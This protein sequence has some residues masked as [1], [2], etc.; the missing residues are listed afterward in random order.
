MS[1]DDCGQVEFLKLLRA[2][3]MIELQEQKNANAD[4]TV[5]SMLKNNVNEL[6]E[7]IMAGIKENKEEKKQALVL[8]KQEKMLART[9]DVVK[10]LRD[11]LDR[12]TSKKDSG[13]D[14][15]LKTLDKCVSQLVIAVEG[16]LP[17]QI[18]VCV[19]IHCIL[20]IG[21]CLFFQVETL[22]CSLLS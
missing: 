17:Y 7:K 5:I 2:E 20:L 15:L 13:Y 18:G 4:A 8:E 9:E 10:N 1:F 14:T 19:Y 21:P 16:T 3:A 22:S 6:A 12:A 11:L